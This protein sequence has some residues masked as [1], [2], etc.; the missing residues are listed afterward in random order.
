MAFVLEIPVLLVH[1]DGTIEQQSW[2]DDLYAGIEAG[3]VEVIRLF[4]GQFQ[5]YSSDGWRDV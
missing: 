5:Y 2:S 3:V 1:E 4:E